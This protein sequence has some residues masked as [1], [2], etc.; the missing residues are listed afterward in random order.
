MEEGG[1]RGMSSTEQLYIELL[2]KRIS[3][4]EEVLH[5][6]EKRVSELEDKTGFDIRSLGPVRC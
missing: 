1:Q 5:I 6:L 3:V 4:L 2:E